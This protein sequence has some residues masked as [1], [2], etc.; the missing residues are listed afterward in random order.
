MSLSIEYEGEHALTACVRTT[1]CVAAGAW[2]LCADVS[3]QVETIIMGAVSIAGL[4]LLN[5]VF[6]TQVEVIIIGA[7]SVTSFPLL[8]TDASTQ[9]EVI[10]IG[11]GIIARFPLRNTVFITPV[12]SIFFPAEYCWGAVSITEPIICNHTRTINLSSAPLFPFTMTTPGPVCT[13]GVG[14]SI[15]AY[16]GEDARTARVQ[17]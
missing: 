8:N 3:T 12:K 14:N 10:I 5:T 7:R 1:N 9:L 6:P 17:F 4:P 16:E 15:C 2:R 13:G 11:A